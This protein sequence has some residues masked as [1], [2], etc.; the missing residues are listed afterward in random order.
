MLEA[1]AGNGVKFTLKHIM[2]PAALAFSALGGLLESTGSNNNM[3][4]MECHECGAPDCNLHV[5]TVHAKLT[6]SFNCS[7][8]LPDFIC[9]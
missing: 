2:H 6:H 3:V 5:I 7:N 1:D 8:C 4:M 9:P